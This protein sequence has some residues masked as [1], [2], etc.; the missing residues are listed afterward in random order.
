MWNYDNREDKTQED[1][2]AKATDNPL[3]QMGVS[4]RAPLQDRSAPKGEESKEATADMGTL[5]KLSQEE[6]LAQIRT[7]V[8]DN[9][10]LE[11][12]VVGGSF[13]ALMH[14]HKQ[15]KSARAPNDIDI[16]VNLRENESIR[17]KS[18][19]LY[20]E[21]RNKPV[22]TPYKLW[23]IPIE[24]HQLGMHI[25]EEDLPASGMH[26]GGVLETK[27]LLAKHVKK[28]RSQNY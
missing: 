4:V 15:G 20:N 2:N 24:L 22:Q 21:L 18:P 11:N 19:E 1:N 7:V 16:I 10:G 5:R 13:A 12:F 23:N 25:K 6:M 9:L 14:A 17:K 8:K 27:T 28:L 3:R 26:G